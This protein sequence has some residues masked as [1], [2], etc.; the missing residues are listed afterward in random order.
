[1]WERDTF[2]RL[3][4]AFGL[5]GKALLQSI[6]KFSNINLS[7]VTRMKITLDNN[8]NWFQHAHTNT[9]MLYDIQKYGYVHLLFEARIFVEHALLFICIQYS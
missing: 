5:L 9:Y 8:A 2:P 6:K 7:Y 3:V 1:M 4:P